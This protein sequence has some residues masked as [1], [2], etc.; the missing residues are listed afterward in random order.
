MYSGMIRGTALYHPDQLV[1]D[2]AWLETR[3]VR[4][5]HMTQEAPKLRK[6][7]NAYNIFILVLTLLSLAV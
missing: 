1:T 2:R 6:P 7:S 3:V 5:I 4:N